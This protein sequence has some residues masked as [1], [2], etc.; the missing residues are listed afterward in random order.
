MWDNIFY[1][2]FD[3]E[4]IISIFISIAIFGIHLKKRKYFV[5]PAL[6]TFALGEL[7]WRLLYFLDSYVYLIVA[8]II[9]I[10][11][12][13]TFDLNFFQGLFL[14]TAGYS[15]QHIM[16]PIMKNKLVNSNKQKVR[17]QIITLWFSFHSNISK[18]Y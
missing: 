12:L 8:L 15:L 17:F 18:L 5:I 7:A 16:I 14:L 11:I 6:I 13:F 10:G 3:S 9:G 4:Y 1:F 2:F